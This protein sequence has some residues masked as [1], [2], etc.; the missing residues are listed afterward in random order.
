MKK[1][2]LSAFIALCLLTPNKSEAHIRVD[3]SAVVD[4]SFKLPDGSY[5]IWFH[6]NFGMSW[7][8]MLDAAGSVI[9][10]NLPNYIVVPGGESSFN[11][12]DLEGFVDVEG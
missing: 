5:R 1:L 7:C 2:I 10:V 11:M 6:C 12:D 9:D 4:A 8:C 3:G